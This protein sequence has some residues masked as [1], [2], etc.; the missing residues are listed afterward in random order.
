MRV[1]TSVWRCTICRPP[2][3]T[4]D[5]TIS[6]SDEEMVIDATDDK[7]TSLQN[8]LQKMEKEGALDEH[9]SQLPECICGDLD[10]DPDRSLKEDEPEEEVEFSRGESMQGTAYGRRKRPPT[11]AQTPKGPA[12]RAKL[13]KS[14]PVRSDT[15]LPPGLTSGCESAGVDRPSLRGLPCRFDGF[16]K[17]RRSVRLEARAIE[18]REN[19]AK[20]IKAENLP[21]GE[22]GLLQ[23][24]RRSRAQLRPVISFPTS[25][26]GGGTAGR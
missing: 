6:H 15:L 18:A 5:G 13:Q 11:K 23:S 25:A 12:K 20:L 19:Q 7:P 17:N 1:P 8:E 2:I 24:M 4:G 3:A 14:P 10:E 22:E 9:A 16:P 26:A 21:H